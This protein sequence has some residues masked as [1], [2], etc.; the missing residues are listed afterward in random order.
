MG[1]FFGKIADAMEKAWWIILLAGIALF[2]IMLLIVV[3]K[4]RRIRKLKRE[5]KTTRTQLEVTREQT[6]SAPKTAPAE[7]E[8]EQIEFDDEQEEPDEDAETDSASQ[9]VAYYNKSAVVSQKGGAVKFTVVYDRPKD[10]W[11]IRKAGVDRV[12]RRVD[13]KEEAMRVARALCKKYDANLVVH[14]KDGRFQKS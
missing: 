11:V 10:S 13:T 5:L 12:V 1:D 4:N 6:G 3:Y 8:E 2:V 7:Q 14:K 9:T